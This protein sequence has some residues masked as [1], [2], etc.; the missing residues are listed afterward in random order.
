VVFPVAYR[1]AAGPNVVANFTAT[2]E[3]H[4]LPAST[5]TDNGSVYTSRFTHGHN[6]FERLLASLGVTQKTATP[7][8]PKPN[9]KSNASTKPSNAG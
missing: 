5:L 2:A 4:G 8:T 7:D 1:R 6:E 9:A 3:R